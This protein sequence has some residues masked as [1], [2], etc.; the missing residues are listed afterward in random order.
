MGQ[1]YCRLWHQSNIKAKGIKD[2][3]I[4]VGKLRTTRQ[5]VGKTSNLLSWAAGKTWKYPKSGIQRKLM[6]KCQCKESW[7]GNIETIT[8]K[9]CKN[10]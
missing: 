6:P 3:L 2:L 1:R 9:K 5:Q 10:S 4:D 7:L 8:T